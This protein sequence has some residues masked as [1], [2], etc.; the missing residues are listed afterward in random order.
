MGSA[1]SGSGLA[2]SAGSGGTAFSMRSWAVRAMRSCGVSSDGATGRWI[3][4]AGVP[5]GISS[6]RSSSGTMA[7]LVTSSVAETSE[8]EGC[9]GSVA[10]VEG[11]SGLV[12]CGADGASP[13]LTNCVPQVMQ[14]RAPSRFSVPQFEH[15]IEL[16]PLISSPGAPN[17]FQLESDHCDVVISAS[18]IGQAHQSLAGLLRIQARRDGLLDLGI[19][20]QATQ[21]V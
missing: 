15:F 3:S 8:S 20:H 14:K 1:G 4:G 9:I 18:P 5:N 21:P 13:G 19:F 12:V 11:S 16:S 6:P 7:G 17:L 10:N 2:S